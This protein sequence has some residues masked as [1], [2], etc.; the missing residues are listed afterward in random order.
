MLK[1][2]CLRAVFCVDMYIVGGDDTRSGFWCLHVEGRFSRQ[3]GLLEV[4]GS[5][6]QARSGICNCWKGEAGD[7]WYGL[8]GSNPGGRTCR[9]SRVLVNENSFSIARPLYIIPISFLGLRAF[10]E[11]RCPDLTV[12]FTTRPESSLLVFPELM[13][14]CEVFRGLVS[15]YT[16][17]E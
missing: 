3:L 10:L 15:V 2:V 7:P 16:V 17:S 6:Q 1:N 12:C 14:A 8:F 9:F 11:V 4:F 13:R 5:V